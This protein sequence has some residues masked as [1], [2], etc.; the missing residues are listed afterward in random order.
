[1]CVVFIFYYI[2]LAVV[3]LQLSV[4]T[5]FMV[6]CSGGVTCRCIEPALSFSLENRHWRTLHKFIGI[7]SQIVWQSRLFSLCFHSFSLIFYLLT[8]VF[9]DTEIDFFS[10]LWL[11]LYSSR[12]FVK[13]I[14]FHYSRN[15]KEQNMLS[16]AAELEERKEKECER[17]TANNENANEHLTV[18]FCVR[19]KQ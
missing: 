16:R 5:N 14:S 19:A 9:S 3:K 2:F 11:V 18:V 13:T 15:R 6:P 12:E 1:M 4:I 8:G 7:R 10:L 17:A